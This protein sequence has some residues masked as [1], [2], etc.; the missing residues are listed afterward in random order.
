MN[1]DSWGKVLEAESAVAARAEIVSRRDRLAPLPR[2]EA[3]P[4]PRVIQDV[5]RDVIRAR[6][7]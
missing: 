1:I 4:L 2:N 3:A 5:I 7:R 6:S